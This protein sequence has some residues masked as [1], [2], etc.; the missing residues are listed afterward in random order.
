M[1]PINTEGEL[2]LPACFIR[3]VNV[4][5]LV[6]QNRVGE[7][8]AIMRV[9]FITNNLDNQSEDQELGGFELFER[10][11]EAIQGAKSYEPALAE[12]CDLKF[13]DMPQT[14]NMTQAYWIDYEVYF[15]VLSS[16]KYKNWIKR[17]IV[18]P[19]FTNFSDMDGDDRPD[20]ETPSYNDQ[21][22]IVDSLIQP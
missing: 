6:Q 15:R 14:A 16:Y 18:I 10:V 21:S 1:S 20:I 8:R 17:K 3:F 7:G 2:A 22:S 13:F 11:N 4:R 19:Q 12:R 9:R 5:Y